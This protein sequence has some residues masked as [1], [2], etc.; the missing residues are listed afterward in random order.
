MAKSAESQTDQPTNVAPQPKPAGRCELR[1]HVGFQNLP[2]GQKVRVEHDQYLVFVDGV[3]VGLVG[4]APGAPINL[5]RR[6]PADVV[7]A[8]VEALRGVHGR[9]FEKPRVSSPPARRKSRR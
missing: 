7:E 4:K 1:P 3:Q 5:L 6:Q 9:D 2:G 8:V